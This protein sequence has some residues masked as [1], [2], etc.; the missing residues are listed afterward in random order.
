[1]S[2]SLINRVESFLN[3]VSFIAFA[4]RDAPAILT[5]IFEEDKIPFFNNKKAHEDLRDFFRGKKM[6]FVVFTSDSNP[7]TISL[8]DTLTA[9]S[10][11]LDNP[12][13]ITNNLALFI[14][15]KIPEQTIFA[16]NLLCQGR[17]KEGEKVMAVHPYWV[18]K[19]HLEI[20]GYSIID[21]RS[22]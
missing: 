9:D 12:K 21:N 6:K 3:N 19:K 7:T 16:V 1:M 10:I 17:T 18:D 4:Y 20:H 11:V 8:V 13:F 14:D 15:A 2:L 22:L 5:F